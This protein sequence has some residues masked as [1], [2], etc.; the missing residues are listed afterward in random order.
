MIENSETFSLLAEIAIAV[1]GFAGVASAFG[2]RERDFGSVEL[3]RL[4]I[5]FFCSM[6]VV[7]GCFSLAILDAAGVS[8]RTNIVL[9]SL[10]VAICSLSAIPIGV[11]H[12][13]LALSTE[14]TATKWQVVFFVAW[15]AIWFSLL[16]ANGI[17]IR[18]E[19]PLIAIFSSCILFSLSLFYRLLTRKS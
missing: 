14:A 7:S 11:R 5:L 9:V 19:W 1:V 17:H 18:A 4:G 15:A 13:R 8:A 16:A 10:L 6:M 3:V 12:A 2:G